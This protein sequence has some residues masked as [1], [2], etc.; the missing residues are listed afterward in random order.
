MG[1][2]CS[3][4]SQLYCIS[5]KKKVNY[6]KKLE[7]VLLFKR[8]MLH[9]ILLFHLVYIAVPSYKPLNQPLKKMKG[10]LLHAHKLYLHNFFFF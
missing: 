4:S 9:I 1:V 5:K 3:K 8:V 10:R 7:F 6:T 2:I